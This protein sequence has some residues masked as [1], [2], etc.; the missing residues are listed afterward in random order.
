MK[1]GP[2]SIIST[3]KYDVYQF[4]SFDG[5]NCYDEGVDRGEASNTY[6]Y[7]SQIKGKGNRRALVE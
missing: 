4:K 6:I 1:N 3:Y 7:L 5:Y 2:P